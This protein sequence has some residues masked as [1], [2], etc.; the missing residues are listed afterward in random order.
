MVTVGVKSRMFA[1]YWRA[2]R[3]RTT[4]SSTPRAPDGDESGGKSTGGNTDSDSTD[5][6]V[7]IPS[8]Q[9][10][11]ASISR[12]ADEEREE[13]RETERRPETHVFIGTVKSP[14]KCYRTGVHSHG[15][16]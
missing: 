14:E 8:C 16:L 2:F 15:A 6:I 7:M 13:K 5:S 12:D 10:Q 4:Q 1:L 9:G 11:N 3:S